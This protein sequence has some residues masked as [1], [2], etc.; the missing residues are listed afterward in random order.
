MF[1]YADTAGTESRLSR[2][3]EAYER[4][5]ARLAEFWRVEPPGP[6][7]VYVYPTQ[8]DI[9]SVMGKASHFA[10]PE[11]H[12]IHTTPKAT[13]GHELTQVFA[14][15]VNASPM[16]YMLG[17]GIAS[18]LDQSRSRLTA[19][20]YAARV[21]KQSPALTIASINTGWKGTDSDYWL[22][23]SFVCD[24]VDSYGPERFLALY[25]MKEPL[26]RSAEKIY[27]VGFD[28]IEGRWHARIDSIGEVTP[29]VDSMMEALS[30]KDYAAALASIDRIEDRLGDA[31]ELLMLKGQSLSKLGRHKEAIQALEGL[32]S[33]KPEALEPPR[34]LQT[35]LYYMGRSLAESGQKNRA[36]H[37]LKEALALDADYR[38]TAAADSILSAL[39]R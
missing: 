3:E 22:S 15:Q 31:S 11:K 25:R 12:E 10:F 8:K 6:T 23:C 1:H 37:H 16:N 28:E 2:S 18:A 29:A 14:Y 24:L 13:T 27:G 21:L 4:A 9:E 17:E 19:D 38:F 39:A 33:R 5:Y 20:Y 35:A 26:E 7:H 34:I 30:R 36:L 32:C